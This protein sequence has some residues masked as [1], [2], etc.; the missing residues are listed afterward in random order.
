MWW[1]VDGGEMQEGVRR[2]RGGGA[3]MDDLLGKADGISG[4]LD[5]IG[6]AETKQNRTKCER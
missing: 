2:F 5:K 4:M 6:R 1:M 3:R